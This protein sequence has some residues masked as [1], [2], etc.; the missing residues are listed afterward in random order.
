MSLSSIKLIAFDLDGTLLDSVPDLTVAVDNAMQAMNKPGVSEAQVRQW[1]GNGADSLVARALSQSIQIA[2]ELPDELKLKARSLF[3]HFYAACGHNQSTLY[4][5]VKE[6]LSALQQQGYKLAIITNKPYQFVPEIL[7]Q[8]QIADQFVDVLGG[9]TLEKRKPDPM[10]L[11]YLMDKHQ[12]TCEQV[13][14][15]GDSKND[16]LAAKNA[17]IV[18]VALP[19]GYNHGEPIE[20]AEPDYLIE[21]LSHLV[22]LLSDF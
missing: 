21:D 3:D 8:H 22:S 6:S 18:S 2:P 15:V 13:I 14:M 17:N 10:P 1:V 12:L 7:A 20:L 19:Y 11:F 16:I 9:D 5:M 4:P